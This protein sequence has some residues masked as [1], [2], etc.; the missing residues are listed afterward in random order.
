MKIFKKKGK[1]GKTPYLVVEVFGHNYYIMSMSMLK[2]HVKY[3]FNPHIA[4]ED[5]IYEH[6][7]ND[8]SVIDNNIPTKPHV[9]NLDEREFYE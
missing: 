4:E 6:I 1:L 3:S 8:M 5:I 7:C 2:E 9:F